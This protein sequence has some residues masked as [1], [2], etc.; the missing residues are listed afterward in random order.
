MLAATPTF[1]EVTTAAA[2]VV[3]AE[4]GVDVAVIE[5]GLGG[6][7]DATNVVTPAVTAITT[8]D[9]DH[10]RHLGNT[11]A[12]IACE[13]AG[14]AKPRRPAGGRARCRRR[15]APSSRRRRQRPGARLI[16]V[17]TPWS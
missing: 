3:F 10:E 9:F 17:P 1:F 14:I 6:R 4:A 16:S 13:K 7:F 15:P 11:L 8:I 12:A 5:V 2:F